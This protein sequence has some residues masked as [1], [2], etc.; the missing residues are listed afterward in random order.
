[1]L[2]AMLLVAVLPKEATFT[3]A[4]GMKLRGTL[5][6][7]ANVKTPVPGVLLL[8]GSGPTDRNGNQP[9][10]LVTD[11]LK[12]I[13]E[14]LA[15]DGV[16]TFRFDKRAAHGY[17]AVWPKGLAA[18]NDF[19]VW[20][21]FVS[22]AKAALKFLGSQPGVNPRKLIIIGHSEGGLI[23]AQIASDTAGKPD[24][25]AALVLMGTAG[26]TLDILV[27]EQVKASLDRSKLTPAVQKPYLDYMEA[28]IKQIKANATVPPNPPQGLGGLFNESASKLMQTYFTLD[29]TKL[30]ARFAGPVLIVQGEK[31]VQVLASKDTPVLERALKA[32]KSGT[33]QTV[34]VPGASHN[35]KAV[36]NPDTDPGFTGPVAPLALGKIAAFV[37]G[38]R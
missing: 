28:A 38:I 17:S 24:A 19:F 25:P 1:M 23:A 22:D 16:A 9:P 27:R 14:R 3:G 2:T 37:I 15:K 8:P 7:P 21:N 29:P 26:R 18:M 36:S 5:D 31:D 30:L 34:I 11:L 20:A 33:V 35:F 10:A 13:A 4:G 6:L 12:Q 32:R